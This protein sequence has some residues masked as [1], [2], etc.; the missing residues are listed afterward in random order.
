MTGRFFEAG[1]LGSRIAFL[2]LSSIR[3]RV[4]AAGWSCSDVE[5]L[6]QV[7]VAQGGPSGHSSGDVIR[8]RR[9]RPLSLVRRSATTPLR[10]L[11]RRRCSC[12]HR[13]TTLGGGRP[14]SSPMPLRRLSR[15]PASSRF[16]RDA[17]HSAADRRDLHRASDQHL[18]AWLEQLSLAARRFSEFFRPVRR[19]LWRV[20]GSSQPKRPPGLHAV[21]QRLARPRSTPM[22]NTSAGGRFEALRPSWYPSTSATPS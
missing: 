22:R 8:A 2:A 9:C 19:V 20:G 15:S 12:R 13:G 18:L 5:R 14:C 11:A 7:V 1:L 6:K 21:D 4:S 3:S 10:H 17:A 16:P